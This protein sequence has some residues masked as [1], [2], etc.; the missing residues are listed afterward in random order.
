MTTFTLLHLYPPPETWLTE[1]C[2]TCFCPSCYP[3]PGTAIVK[4]WPKKMDSLTLLT[5]EQQQLGQSILPQQLPPPDAASADGSAPPPVPGRRAGSSETLCFELA[6]SEL[7]GIL[8]IMR[9]PNG[10]TWTQN[11]TQKEK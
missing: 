11:V 4:K 9:M 7:I 10:V 5:E 8:K 3:S 6:Y 2:M 1:F